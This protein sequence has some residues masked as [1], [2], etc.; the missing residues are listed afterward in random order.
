METSSAEGSH[1]RKCSACKKPMAFGAPYYIC[2]VSTC[3]NPRTG[4]AFCTVSCFETHLPGARHREA[5]AIEKRAPL[6]G[7]FDAGPAPAPA[8]TAAATAPGGGQRKLIR[9]AGVQSSA[10]QALPRETLIIASRLKEY[11]DARANFNTSGAVVD[12][13][14]DYVRILCD[15]AIDHA[16]EDG[17]KTLME[18]DFEFLRKQ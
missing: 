8:T 16:R 10:S 9:P 12:M 1:W 17:R 5:G 14:S 11:V 2:S 18:R 3:N 15:R 4:Y 6:T 13:L 7:A